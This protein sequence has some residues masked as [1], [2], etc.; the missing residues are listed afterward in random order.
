MGISTEKEKTEMENKIHAAETFYSMGLLTEAIDAYREIIDTSGELADETKKNILEKIG[1]I[2]KE[3]KLMDENE[4]SDLTVKELDLIKKTLVGKGKGDISQI[5]N[6]GFALR[7]LGLYNDALLE[8]DKLFSFEYPKIKIVLEMLEC[9]FHIHSPAESI[10]KIQEIMD[11]KKVRESDKNQINNMLA[12]EMEKRGQ[13]DLMQELLR[14]SDRGGKQEGKLLQERTGQRKDDIDPEKKNFLLVGK[15]EQKKEPAEAPSGTSP[16]TSPE[17]APSQSQ[18]SGSKWDQLIAK[19]LVDIDQLQKALALSKKLNKSVEYVLIEQFK[20][21][22]EELGLSLSAYS[23]CK[24]KSFDPNLPVP[25]ELISNLKKAFLLNEVWI[26]LSWSKDGVEILV[27]DPKDLTKTDRIGALVKAKKLTFS[28]GIKEDIE[29]YINL[30]FGHKKRE[31]SASSGTTEDTYEMLPDISFEED[32]EERELSPEEIVD[33]S[34]SKIVRFVDQVLVTAY[35]DKISDI[36]IE[37]STVTKKTMIRFRRDGVCQEYVSVPNTMAKAILSRVKIMSNLDIAERRLPQDGKIKFRRKGIPEFELRVATLPTTGGFED[38]VLRIL[39]KAGAMPLDDMGLTER[40]LSVLK[41][42]IAQPY[43]L[44]LVVGPTGSGKTTTLHAA[45]GYINKPG[46]K[47]WTAEDPVEITQNGLRQV[48]VKPKIGL[49]FARVMRAF[50]RADPD[51]IMIGEMRDHETAATGVEASLTGHLVFSTL[52][53]N[54]APETITRLLDMGLNPLN[55]SD[56]FRGVLAQ[57]LV[58]RLCSGCKQEYK[59]SQEELDEIIDDFG[60]ESFEKLNMDLD[61]ITLFQ[62]KGCDKCNG[63][64]YRGRMGIHEMMEGTKEIKRMIKKESPA[65]ELFLQAAEDGMLTLRQD[66]ILKVLHGFSDM[67]EIRRVCID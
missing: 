5:L 24:F 51:V 7:E 21:D 4:V 48:E 11:A 53:T 52:H 56:A 44:I 43:G 19:K 42:I 23:G 50:L 20:I 41:H 14:H 6:S 46:I 67:I 65:E 3:A 13:K 15:R 27:D 37:P 59:A 26:P 36:H 34:S 2:Q 18:T 45:L 39:A 38:A 28:I 1:T 54:S 62:T 55:F 49:D 64:G 33:E 9:L 60:R 47:I 30:F 25:Y 66:G 31:D 57:R 40:N 32:S 17:T 22:K 10:Q 16:E 63:S 8:Y 58:R 29:A 35:R 61:K 12:F